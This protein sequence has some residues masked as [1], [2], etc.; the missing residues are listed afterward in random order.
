[1]KYNEL[2]KILKKN[3]CYFLE[4]SKNGHPIWFSPTTQKKFRMS[5]HRSEEVRNG[6]LKSILRDAG[7]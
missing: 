3:G 1:M 7:I 5:N 4:N 6:T 2:E